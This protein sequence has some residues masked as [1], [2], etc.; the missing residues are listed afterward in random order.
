MLAP[1]EALE[2][3]VGELARR[4]PGLSV[5]QT[6]DP[7][8]VPVVEVRT[9]LIPD[10]VARVQVAFRPDG[11]ALIATEPIGGGAIGATAHL[12][13]PDPAA[14]A[15][16]I[17]EWATRPLRLP[18]PKPAAPAERRKRTQERVRKA[19]ADAAAPPVLRDAGYLAVADPALIAYHFPRDRRGRMLGKATVLLE[20][21]EFGSP[22]KRSRCRF[23]RLTGG[24]FESF[25]SDQFVENQDHR[26]HLQSW[27]WRRDAAVTPEQ[28]WGVTDMNAAAAA[29][30]DLEAGRIVEGFEA[31][32]V[33]LGAGLVKILA[34]QPLDPVNADLAGRW[35]TV[36]MEELA[37]AAP[38]RLGSLAGKTWIRLFGLGGSGAQVR[39]VVALGLRDRVP[40]VDFA[41]LGSNRRL[42]R[43][44]WE[45][46][47]DFEARRLGLD[48]IG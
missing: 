6:V 32:G 24:V 43:E 16:A 10:G 31:F 9:M 2:A 21:L 8:D 1:E 14:V 42:A 35:G 46:S 39:P 34:G 25:I 13:S 26:W 33:E 23:L 12:R 11:Y 48:E 29:A 40:T 41:A 15:E 36:A 28:R 45:R 4:A 22:G 44:D 7:H 37:A 19:Q 38:W 20:I 17:A 30:A 18:L 5:T 27:R 47:L 3:V